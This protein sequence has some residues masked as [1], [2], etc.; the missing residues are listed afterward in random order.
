MLSGFVTASCR[1]LWL[2]PFLIL[3]QNGL[4]QRT[5]LIIKRQP[6]P[7]SPAADVM[8]N[9]EPSCRNRSQSNDWRHIKRKGEIG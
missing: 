8:E 7:A 6:K 4:L 1:S 5:P 2:E 9:R 3:S